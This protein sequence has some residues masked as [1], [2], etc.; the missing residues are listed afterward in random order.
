MAVFEMNLAPHLLRYHRW[1]LM[2]HEQILFYLGQLNMED[3]IRVPETATSLKQKLLFAALVHLCVFYFRSK[4]HCEFLHV[5]C[6]LNVVI[7][8]T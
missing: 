5:K 6:Q 8:P 7:V 2:G 4:Q 3:T 1:K